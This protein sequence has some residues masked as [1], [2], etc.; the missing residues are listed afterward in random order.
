MALVAVL[1]AL[2]CEPA[3]PQAQ[4]TATPPLPL[5]N[6][7]RDAAPASVP[8][9]A[10]APGPATQSRPPHPSQQDELAWTDEELDGQQTRCDALLQGVDAVYEKQLP[11]KEGRC[12][13]AIPLK[14]TS[15]GRDPVI[16]IGGNATLTCEM[17]AALSL[18]VREVLQPEARAKLGS[19]IA[20]FNTVSSYVCRNRYGDPGKP[21]SEHALANALDIASFETADGQKITVLDNWPLPVN[22]PL[23][24]RKPT[25]PSPQHMPLAAQAVQKAAAKPTAAAEAADQVP[26][27]QA[28]AP[29][30]VT[31]ELLETGTEPR[32]KPETLPADPKAQFLR[33]V[34]AGACKVFGTALGPEA[35]AAHRDHFHFDMAERRWSNFC[36]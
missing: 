32:P 17:V 18:W 21:I 16:S 10:P 8:V 29:E 33:D 28:T 15:I 36:Q 13:A 27:T 34:H 19:P 26:G 2:T 7:R 20:R 4:E 35:N 14:L 12:G 6:P 1:A 31:A 22:I 5:R 24:L 9:P 30:A 11:I 25:P 3:L 23:P